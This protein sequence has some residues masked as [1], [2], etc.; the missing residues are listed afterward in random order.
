MRQINVFIRW[1]GGLRRFV[2]LSPPKSLVYVKTAGVDW[3]EVNLRQL[4]DEF[5]GS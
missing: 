3:S 5:A 2:F 1:S 4:R